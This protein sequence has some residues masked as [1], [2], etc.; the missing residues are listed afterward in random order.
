MA[1]RTLWLRTWSQLPCG[2]VSA[3][4]GLT[5][6]ILNLNGQQKCQTGLT[7]LL[8]RHTRSTGERL[9]KAVQLDGS[10]P[11][12]LQIQRAD[13][14]P[15]W[16]WAPVM[17][18]SK[19]IRFRKSNQGVLRTLSSLAGCAHASLSYTSD[20]WTKDES[21]LACSLEFYWRQ[22]MSKN[23]HHTPLL[24][25]LVWS[26]SEENCSFPFYLEDESNQFLLKMCLLD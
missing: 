24:K 5:D 12:A 4:R 13:A 3:R 16:Q 9:R 10:I 21:V 17:Q 19:I 25:L 20:W 6:C 8:S 26:T 15:F 1:P 22:K 11:P 14:T 23:L 2:G 7:T 18:P